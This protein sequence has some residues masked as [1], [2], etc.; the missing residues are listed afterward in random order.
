MASAKN[1]LSFWQG[2]PEKKSFYAVNEPTVLQWL[3][4][5]QLT[6]ADKSECLQGLWQPTITSVGY[7]ALPEDFLREYPNRVKS[8]TNS[9]GYPLKKIPYQ[10]AQILNLTGTALYSIYN[11]YFYVWAAGACTPNVPYIKKPAEI[12]KA[13]LATAELELP[14]QMHD[15]LFYFL[16]SRYNMFLGNVQNMLELESIFERKAQEYLTTQIQR[17]DSV[18]STRGG[19]F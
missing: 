2:T 9:L 18:P 14:T 10:D 19:F 12:T 7:I 16:E 4:D 3:N 5:A 13:T 6:F 8:S 17:N 11:G 1:I 15:T